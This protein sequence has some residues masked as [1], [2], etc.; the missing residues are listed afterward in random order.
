MILAALF[1]TLSE[2]NDKATYEEIERYDFVED[3]THRSKQ[4]TIIS[5][6]DDLC[7]FFITTI[8]DGIAWGL[9]T[10]NPFRWRGMS[11]KIEVAFR[12]SGSWSVPVC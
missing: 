11:D 8:D 4:L 9:Q 6:E 10:D 2:G 7:S 5:N 12:A 1:G 3:F